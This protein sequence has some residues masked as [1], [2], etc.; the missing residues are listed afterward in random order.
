MNQEYK[1]RILDKLKRELGPVIEKALEA[2]DVIEI[3]LNP[4]GSIWI[5]RLGHDMV[6]SGTMTAAAAE[7]LMSTIATTLHTS[8]T[9]ENPIIEGELIIDGSR[10]EGMIPPVVSHPVFTIRKKASIIFTLSDYVE[11]QIMSPPQKEIIQDAVKNRKNI[12]VVGGT[13]SGKTTLTNSIIDSICQ[14]TPKHRLVIIEDTAEI[15]CH[16]QN[17][18]LLHSTDTVDMLRLLK[19]TMRL[20]P[21]RIIVGEVRGGEA[22]ALLKAWNTGHPG[23]VATIH[24]NSAQ[25]GL[26]RLEQL[27]SEAIHTPQQK[28]IAE[29]VD[30]IIAIEKTG[31]TRK[32][33][34]IISTSGFENGN[35]KIT[36][37]L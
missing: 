2:S 18:V 34:Q 36:N 28:L 19:A 4:N 17:A 14:L 15:Q 32:V 7:S 12:L 31:R 33:G 10:F 27:I 1:K 11:Q 8:I 23:G 26:V 9:R 5:E 24:A 37:L 21:D 35:Y 16:A 3:M 29:A 25:A 30:L 13:G 20:R 6:Q 22:L